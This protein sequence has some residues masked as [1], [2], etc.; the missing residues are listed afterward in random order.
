M[1]VILR[2]N[3]HE[4]IADIEKE[5]HERLR[6]GDTNSFIYIAPTKRKIRDLKREFLKMA[7]NGVSPA[8]YL[9][10]LETLTAQLY[11]LI[12]PPRRYISG[13]VQAVLMSE[14]VHSIASSL[15]YFHFQGSAKKLPKGTLQKI[16][17]VINTFKAKGIYR[18][19][20]MNELESAEKFEKPKLQDILSIYDSY[21]TLL[22]DRFVDAAGI[23]KLVNEQWDEV[24]APAETKLFFNN[25]DIIFVSGFDEFS[26]PELTILNNLSNIEGIGMLVLFDYHLENDEVFGH[27]KENYRKFIENGFQKITTPSNRNKIFAQHIIEHLFKYEDN[28]QKYPCSKKVTLL[29]SDDRKAEVELIAKLIKRLLI[30]EPDR[31]LSRICVAMYRPQL[32]TNL[33]R[34]VFGQFGIPVNITDRYYL[35]QSP[36]VVSIVSLLAVQQNNFRLNDIMR[37]LS[38]P[39]LRLTEDGERVDADNLYEVAS[40]LKIT[41]G[42]NSWCK[43]IE[44]RLKKISSGYLEVDDERDSI[45]FQH[46]AHMLQKA[47]TDLKRIRTLLQPFEDRMM[48]QEFKERLLSLLDKVQIV[49]GILSGRSS[50]LDDEKLEKDTR[51]YQKFLLFLDEFFEILAFERKDQINENL[52]FYVNRLREAISQVRYNI[53]LKYG[54]GVSVTSFNETRGLNFDVMIVAGLIDGEFPP[55]YQPEIF[56]SS[57]RRAQKE[58][59]H[60]HE[61]RYLFYQAITNFSDHLYIT[62]PRTDSEI[63]LVPSSFI[64]ALTKIIDLEDCSNKTPVELSAPIYSRHELLRYLGQVENYNINHPDVKDHV[65]VDNLDE[66][67]TG[68]LNQ[69]RHA[70]RIEGNRMLNEP[71]SEYNGDIGKGVN[72]NAKIVLQRFR[73]RVYSVTQL[74]S[75]GRCPFQFFSNK[76]LRLN[77]VKEVEEGI[78]PPEKGGIIHDILFEFYIERRKKHNAPLSQIDD[79][80]FKEAL[81]DLLEIAQ[82]KLHELNIVDIFWDVDKE[83]II[84]SKNRKGALREFLELERKNTY[85]VQPKYFEAA[86]GPNVGMQDKTDPNF[87]FDKPVLAGNVRLRGKVDRIDLGENIF[88]VVDYK[89]GTKLAAKEDIDIGMSLQL[90]IYLYAIEHILTTRFEGSYRGAAGVYYILNSPVTEKLGI[91]SDE[92][93]GKAFEARKSNQLVE[94][95]EDL[96]RVIDQAIKFVDEY[97]DNIAHGYFPV[98]PKKPEK[99]CVYC[100]F[101]TICRIQPKFFS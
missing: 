5:V 90:P 33:F 6:R 96:R 26:D 47:H 11:S 98:A 59:Y 46:E 80:Q 49:E 2:K 32:Y 14:A 74:E 84:G 51:A 79:Q 7:P 92:H 77:V 76:V 70:V 43:R 86:F 64:K 58:S 15:R 97:V 95:D 10:T 57:N 53:R 42:W 13:T 94:T 12:C 67:L 93:R 31:D 54:Y 39:Y 72:D 78:S 22:G 24:R 27:L 23:F 36:L 71:I 88:R 85:T 66:E 17:D 19:T 56:F 73:E 82:R 83:S 52:S 100:E 60:L 44:D 3:Y 65:K 41:V 99:V 101:R 62:Y 68:I 30:E 50:L 40:L 61:N 91:G 87:T 69:M 9:F 55:I 34:E 4:V 38:S 21:E 1:P 63:D 25:I 28:A 89:T 35:D 45:Q 75:Y 8:P 81:N 20:L 16:I 48:P 37:A 18:S 29:A